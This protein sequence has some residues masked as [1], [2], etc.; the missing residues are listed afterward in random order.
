MVISTM[1][2]KQGGA[3]NVQK[4]VAALPVGPF[5][6]ASLGRCHLSTALKEVREPCGDLGEGHP[7]AGIA[8][9]K[10]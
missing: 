8:S 10:A 7:A 4:R 3:L 6:A 9:A 1:D 2:S 5:Q